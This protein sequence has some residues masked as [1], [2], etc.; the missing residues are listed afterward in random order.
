MFDV[1][2]WAALVAQLW[3]SCWQCG[4][5]RLQRAIRVVSEMERGSPLAVGIFGNVWPTGGMM[6]AAEL[7]SGIGCGVSMRVEFRRVLRGVAVAIPWVRW[8]C[9]LALMPVKI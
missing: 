7:F 5:V 8:S 3:S 4:Q 6:R 2:N 1:L 9:W